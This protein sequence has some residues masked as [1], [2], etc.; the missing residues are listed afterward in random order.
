MVAD[1]VALLGRTAPM[2]RLAGEEQ[3]L[4]QGGLAGEIGSH[5]RRAAR[6]SRSVGHAHLLPVSPTGAVRSVR[7][8]AT[9]R[10]RL[11]Q[12]KMVARLSAWCNGNFRRRGGTPTGV[13]RNRA[14]PGRL[15]RR[16]AYNG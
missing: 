11:F 1:G 5:Q 13:R 9:P 12:M 10:R 3:R 2:R 6:A 14:R 15:S 4:E 8:I 7:E 16:L